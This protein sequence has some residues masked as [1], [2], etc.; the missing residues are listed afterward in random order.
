MQQNVTLVCFREGCDEIVSLNVLIVHTKNDTFKQELLQQVSAL[1]S[2][3]L[4]IR[5]N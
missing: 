3:F 1:L 2:V 4:I 5:L